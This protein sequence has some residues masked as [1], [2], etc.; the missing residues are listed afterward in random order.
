MINETWNKEFHSEKKENMWDSVKEQRL[1]LVGRI[2]SSS[3][4]NDEFSD[5]DP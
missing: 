1:K 4:K 5:G 3:W 2:W